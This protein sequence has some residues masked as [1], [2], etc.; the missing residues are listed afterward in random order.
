MASVIE[1][2]ISWSHTRPLWQRD[3]LRR[4]AR[5][6]VIDDR[7]IGVYADA[8]IGKSSD[9]LSPLSEGELR[10][11]PSSETVRLIAIRDA[12][13]VNSLASGQAMTFGLHGLTVVYGDNG[14]G[15][16]G[17]ARILKAVTRTR[18]RQEV[19]NDIFKEAGLVPTAT[20]E[21]RI[22]DQDAAFTW[23]S[24][25]SGPDPLSRISFFDSACSDI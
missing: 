15:K 20:V 17:Y 7:T 3:A 21:F 23:T 24:G 19:R 18:A 9:G 1:E 16:S 13:N 10:S 5:G 2:I 22:G 4:L 12:Q 8:A 25:S 6:E 11:T 14:A